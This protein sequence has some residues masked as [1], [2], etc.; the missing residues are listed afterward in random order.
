MKRLPKSARQAILAYQNSALSTDVYFNLLWPCVQY[1]HGSRWLRP[2]AIPQEASASKLSGRYAAVDPCYS[3]HRTVDLPYY[4]K[5]RTVDVPYYQHQSVTGDP[6]ATNHTW[7][8]FVFQTTLWTSSFRG[9]V[10]VGLKRNEHSYCVKRTSL[11]RLF[12]IVIDTKINI[13]TG[14]I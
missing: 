11:Y 2:H 7:Q 10:G 8:T 4:F 1:H 3:K 6:R 9:T 5:H 12:I 14:F 13:L